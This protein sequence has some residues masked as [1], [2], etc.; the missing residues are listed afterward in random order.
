ME[1]AMSN[2]R[3]F[4]VRVR[5]YVVVAVVALVIGGGIIGYLSYQVMPLQTTRVNDMWLITDVNMDG[6]TD[7]IV[8]ADIIFSANELENNSPLVP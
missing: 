6:K 3:N 1:T 7:I 2:V 4:I 8:N 5:L